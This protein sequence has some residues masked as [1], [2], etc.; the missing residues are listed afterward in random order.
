[1]IHFILSIVE[2]V[3]SKWKNLSDGFKKCLDRK[4]DLEKSGSGYSKPPTCRFYNQ[5]LFLRDAVSNRNTHSNVQV[6]SISLGTPS[7][8]EEAL[9]EPLTVTFVSSLGNEPPQQNQNQQP[10]VPPTTQPPPKEK[11]QFPQATV[12]PKKK[13]KS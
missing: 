5:L 1:M 4:R 12:I 9:S 6:Q 10:P 11:L 3:K 8:T 7:S 2:Q 13:E